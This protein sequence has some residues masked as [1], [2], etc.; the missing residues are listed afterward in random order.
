MSQKTS[1][2]IN[3]LK[4]QLLEAKDDS[5]RIRF[6]DALA[7]GYRFSNVDSSLFYDDMAINLANKWASQKTGLEFYL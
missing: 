4:N 7:S 2:E 1:K 5:V 6:M 3:N